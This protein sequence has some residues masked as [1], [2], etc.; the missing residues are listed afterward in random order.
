[1]SKTVFIFVSS[2]D[3]INQGQKINKIPPNVFVLFEAQPEFSFYTFYER[4]L[5]TDN[6]NIFVATNPKLLIE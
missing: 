4:I 6:S 3:N 1:M 2:T 5:I